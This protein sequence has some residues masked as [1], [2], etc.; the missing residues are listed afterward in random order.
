MEAKRNGARA[1]VHIAGI[2]K[3][4]PAD[5]LAQQRKAQFD[6]A[7]QQSVTSERETCGLRGNAGGTNRR[8]NIARPGLILGK[9]AMRNAAAAKEALRQR[10]RVRRVQ[11]GRD[12][13]RQDS[14]ER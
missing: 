5:V 12:T 2:V 14:S 10:Y 8:S 6:I 1:L 3:Q 7:E 4:D 11:S 13:K 9:P